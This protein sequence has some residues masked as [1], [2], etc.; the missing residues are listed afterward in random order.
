MTDR[1]SL[2]L[3]DLQLRDW[4]S[5]TLFIAAAAVMACGAAIQ[6]SAFENKNRMLAIYG[7][8]CLAAWFYWLL[9]LAT[10]RFHE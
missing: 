6:Y 7:A 10:M 2:L 9:I 1:M 5:V 4:I 8:L 3:Y